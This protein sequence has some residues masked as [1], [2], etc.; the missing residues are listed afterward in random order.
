SSARQRTPA[1][2][3]SARAD[4]GSS[5]AGPRIP[6]QV[7]AAALFAGVATLGFEV[8]ATRA[9]ALRLGSSLYAWMVVLALFLASLAM[10][11]ALF[12][13]S[14]AHSGDPRRALGRVEWVAAL[15]L[16][17]AAAWLPPPPQLP[18]AGLTRGS[19][20]RLVAC[21]VPGALCMGA[22]FPYLVRLAARDAPTLA[23]A[24]GRISA[25]NIA[26]GVGGSLL[27]P[28]VLL[29]LLGPA[30]GML[31]CAA[32]NAAIGTAFLVRGAS[33]GLREVAAATLV[34]AG[35]V[36][37]A[38]GPRA[39]PGPALVLAVSHGRQ[40]TAAVVRVGDRRD[41]ILD[42]EREA[43][44]AG[45]A[46]ATEEL[47]A[48]VPLLLHPDPHSLLEVGFGSG[49]TLGAVGRFPLGRIDCVEIA[50]SVLAVAPWF[51]PYN[52]YASTLTDA[53][54]RI[55]RADGRAWLA[56][57]RGEYDIILA[58]TL[59]PWSVGASGLYSREYFERVAAALR[60]G[61]VAAQWL[62]VQQI[63]LD[64][65]QD[66]LRTYFAVF[67]E[68][69]LYWGAENVIAIGSGSPLA[70]PDFDRLPDATRAT[71]RRLGLEDAEEL[72]MR[73][74]ASASTVRRVL[75]PGPLLSDD[76]PSLEARR[77]RRRAAR[78]EALAVIERLAAGSAESEPAAGPLLLWLRALRARAAGD[79][80][81]ADRDERLAE[82]SGLML[83]ALSRSSRLVAEAGDALRE[84]RLDEADERLRR[85][86]EL[87]PFDATARFGR[88]AVDA[89][90][91]KTAS[92]EAR[93]ILLVADEPRHAEA[94]NLLGVLRARGGRVA[95][96]RAA[97]AS[98]LR[99]DP[100]YPA[101][102]VS[103]GRVALGAGDRQAALTMLARLHDLG[104]WGALP[105]EASLRA[106][107]GG[108][109]R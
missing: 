71:L 76:L 109:D 74:V 55:V 4:P 48:A 16:A 60:P 51:E 32:V 73:R 36:W 47:L 88:A 49:I 64:Q 17:L 90:R 7:A 101:A 37:M 45:T 62:P 3:A 106:A 22:A 54:T 97:F 82:R 81:A 80:E 26:G 85:A 53:R 20:L 56:R 19:L 27:A 6:P 66:I 84:G 5:A 93:L 13:R 92:A 98:A 65:L 12:A 105:E 104:A 67:P 41:L 79:T 52:R 24:F 86:Q 2:D 14:A 59:R 100:F 29:P 11:N 33:R 28:F 95:E 35:L 42:G 43:S 1:A 89:E 38:V 8:L 77:L 46:R 75:G 68:G 31:A 58:N 103:A 108:G 70:E 78:F 34:A 10:G 44:T 39:L 57:H 83:A 94:W 40:A 25:W 99:A 72:E 96:A 107:L 91:G 21:I 69:A 102:L 87:R 61:G 23:A 18:A 63:Q 9:A 30:G 15:A 50:P